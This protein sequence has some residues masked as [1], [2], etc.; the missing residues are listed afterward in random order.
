MPQVNYRA[1]V[2][3]KMSCVSV[4]DVDATTHKMMMAGWLFESWAPSGADPDRVMLAFT[5]PTEGVA[6]VDV[7]PIMNRIADLCAPIAN[8]GSVTRHPLDREQEQ[9]VA[10]GKLQAYKEVLGIMHRSLGV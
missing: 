10:A 1:A 6:V 8:M 9:L 4:E 5:R 2:T 7:K 3:H